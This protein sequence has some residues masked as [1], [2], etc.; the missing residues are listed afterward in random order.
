MYQNV[1]YVLYSF[2]SISNKFCDLSLLHWV[3]KPEQWVLEAHVHKTTY[4]PLI[5]TAL[6]LN[7]MLLMRANPLRG[8][9]YKS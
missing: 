2:L 5:D 1:L 6:A 9:L 4:G 3:P 7:V 8:G